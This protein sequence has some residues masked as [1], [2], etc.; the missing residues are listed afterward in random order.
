MLGFGVQGRSKGFYH[1]YPRTPLYFPPKFS[2]SWLIRV[3]RL[4]KGFLEGGAVVRRTHMPK[5]QA[6]GTKGKGLGIGV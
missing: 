3:L 2:I 1:G 6:E 4:I 5:G